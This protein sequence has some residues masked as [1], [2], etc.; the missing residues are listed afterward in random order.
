VTFAPGTIV[1]TKEDVQILIPDGATVAKGSK[2]IVMRIIDETFVTVALPAFDG[3]CIVFDHEQL[4][5][6]E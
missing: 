2:G 4:E 5:F 3:A 6:V 1:R